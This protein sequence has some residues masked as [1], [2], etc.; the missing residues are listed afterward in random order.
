MRLKFSCDICIS[1]YL[2]LWH[3][4]TFLRWV[5]YFHK[6]KLTVAYFFLFFSLSRCSLHLYSQEA[7]VKYTL[8]LL[9][10]MYYSTGKAHQNEENEKFS[11]GSSVKFSEVIHTNLHLLPTKMLSLQTYQN[12]CSFSLERI[13]SS[14][15]SIANMFSLSVKVCC[16]CR[17]Y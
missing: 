2:G 9:V 14:C 1:L 17:L 13:A 16:K 6:Y 10:K 11:I 8:W 4:I 7:A 12:S 15:W 3:S 5:K